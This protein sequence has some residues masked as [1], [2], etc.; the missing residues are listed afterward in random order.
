MAQAGG[1]GVTLDTTETAT[2]FGEDQARYL[3]ACNFDEAEALMVEAGRV[4]GVHIETVGRFTGDAVRIGG[5]EAPPLS[6]LEEAWR[7]GFDSAHR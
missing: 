6:E 1:V 5:S 3:V 7:T 2:L 4:G